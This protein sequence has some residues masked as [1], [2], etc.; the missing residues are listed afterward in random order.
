[1]K[2]PYNL[3]FNK[4]VKIKKLDS[5]CK[6][7][8]CRYPLDFCQE[9]YMYEVA[10]SSIVSQQY[11][12]RPFYLDVIEIRTDMKRF[13]VGFEVPEKQLLL[14]FLL[15][16]E[17]YFSTE[18]QIPITSSKSGYFFMSYFDR[19]RYLAHVKKGSLLG[20][21]LSISPLWIEDISEDFEHIK[22]V[23]G[24]FE[25]NFKAYDTYH[26]GK[27]DHRVF[28]HLKNILSFGKY[29]KG[30]MDGHIRKYIALILQHYNQIIGKKFTELPFRIIDYLDKHYRD[31][32]LSNHLLI[33]IF[34]VTEKTLIGQ[35][36]E[37]FK[38][39]PHQYYTQRRMDHAN[40]LINS[41]NISI[42]EVYL[43]VGYRNEK[44]FRIAYKK[45]FNEKGDC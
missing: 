14:I 7:K 40:R 18:N 23:L 35:F 5:R 41:E 1:M 34:R 26:H 33:E 20:L 10:N 24:E 15:E 29:P 6:Y 42:E 21:T 11:N 39:T 32:N 16:G 25:K 17:V 3:Y 28:R 9:I 2:K 27:I 45:H 19:G 4:P 37:E 44:A 22:R 38:V 30:I 13:E 8:L 36:K 12:H 31:E 43:L